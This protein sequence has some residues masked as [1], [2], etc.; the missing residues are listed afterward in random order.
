[1]VAGSPGDHGIRIDD[2][3]TGT[4]VAMAGYTEPVWMPDGRAI[5]TSLGNRPEGGLG[6]QLA[7]ASQGIDT[8]LVM[9]DGDSWPTDVSRDGKWLAWYGATFGEGPAAEATDPNDLFIMD[10]AKRESRRIPLAGEQ[11]GA[12]FSPDGRWLAYQSTES[13]RQGIHIRPFPSLDANWVI[14]TDGGEEPAWS[15]DGRT[16][17]YRQRDA[18]I[19][20]GLTFRGATLDRAPARE[21]F[22]G[23]YLRDHYGDVSWDVASDGRFLMLRPVRGSRLQVE[24]MLNWIE[25]VRA[26]LDRAEREGTR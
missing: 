13:G 5:I 1:M 9:S 14:S 7:D 8:L 26:R 19:A 12:R 17:Y 10:I 20:V 18:V 16:L 11:R 6:M 22:K 24:V 4:R 3:R 25:E 2:L 15:P 23:T 21:L